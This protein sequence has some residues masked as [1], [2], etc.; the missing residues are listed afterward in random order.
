MPTAGRE[1][2]F[3]QKTSQ[4]ES[5]APYTILTGKSTPL[6]PATGEGQDEPRSDHARA[7]L[8]SLIDGP[9][10]GERKKRSLTDPAALVGEAKEKGE[11]LREKARGFLR[12]HDLARSM[13][14]L[15]SH[16]NQLRGTA[17]GAVPL[18]SRAEP[19]RN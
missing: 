4:F 8:A 15:A 12:Y 17:A 1:F 3:Y 13:P 9:E 2:V 6:S 5:T 14:S 10:A 16:R 19:W 7:G 11:N 18:E